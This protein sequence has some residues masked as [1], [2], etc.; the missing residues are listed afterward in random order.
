MGQ[1]LAS[2]LLPF[3]P[4]GI[5]SKIWPKKKEIILMQDTAPS[6]SS[7]FTNEYLANRD[8]MEDQDHDTGGCR[9]QILKI[10]ELEIRW[11]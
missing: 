3:F 8:L 7:K 11:L 10:Y 1:Y 5:I 9:S 2:K 6:H 4:L